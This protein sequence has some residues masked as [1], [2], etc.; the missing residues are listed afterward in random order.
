MNGRDLPISG[1]KLLA[2]DIKGLPKFSRT[3]TLNSTLGRDMSGD[4]ELPM[5]RVRQDGSIQARLGGAHLNVKR[6][7]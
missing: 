3:A 2:F 1:L 6:A 7:P 5:V 4:L